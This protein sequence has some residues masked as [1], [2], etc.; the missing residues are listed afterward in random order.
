MGSK[1]VAEGMQLAN[2]AGLPGNTLKMRL[3]W[4]WPQQ[5]SDGF[6]TGQESASLSCPDTQAAVKW[7]LFRLGTC[8]LAADLR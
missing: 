6:D 8:R 7:R 5:Q 2:L 1:P 3:A 4:P